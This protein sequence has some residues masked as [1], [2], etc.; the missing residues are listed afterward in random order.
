MEVSV[1]G[2]A[3]FTWDRR[4]TV[5]PIEAAPLRE[6]DELEGEGVAAGLAAAAGGGPAKPRIDVLLS[7][8]LVFRASVTDA[9]VALSVGNR[10]RKI[11]RVV[12]E[13]AWQSGGG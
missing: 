3:S 10:L 13:R 6:K 7:G 5:N 8:E 4:G 9:N 11:V 1:R 12:G 2:K